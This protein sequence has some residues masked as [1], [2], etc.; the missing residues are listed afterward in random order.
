MIGFVNTDFSV[1]E[2]GG[3]VGFDLRVL[4]GMIDP[5]LGDAIVTLSTI[6]RTAEGQFTRVHMPT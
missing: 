1:S 2:A 4:A 3:A 5:A 6:E